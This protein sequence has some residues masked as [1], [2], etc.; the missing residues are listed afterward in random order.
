MDQDR[1]SSWLALRAVNGIGD[2]LYRRLIDKFGSPQN[3]FSAGENELLKVEGIRSDTVA[4]IRSAAPAVPAG[5]KAGIPE[6]E[7]ILFC[8]IL[9]RDY[10]DRVR[11][12]HDPP[13]FLF[14]KGGLL[15]EDR[16]SIAVVGSRNC[17][18]YGRSVAHAL[19]RELAL[20]GFTI[21]S[22]LARG[23]DAAAH[24]G[25]LSAG[26][27][28]IGV[29]GCGLDIAYPPG[30]A[31]LKSE[32]AANGAVITEFPFGTT[33]DPVNFPKR[34][35]LISGLS[36]G[37]IVVEAAEKSGALITASYA[38]D[39]GREVF[40]VPGPMGSETSRGPHL[41]I[42]QGARL[43]DGVDDILEELRPSLT[44]RVT[45]DSKGV[46]AARL[47]D[48][49]VLTPGERRVFELLSR[50]P[51]HLDEL[52][53]RAKASSSEMAGW[54]LQLELKGAARHLAGQRYVRGEI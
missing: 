19:S 21:V 14:I 9:D 38:L 8:T 41:L 49:L 32:I 31:A 28:T 4:S 3:V 7:S 16:Q 2:V 25:A 46:P 15:P 54:L 26:G 45:E 29:L 48:P 10:P 6:D 11:E 36:L 35:R 39:Q 24:E 30:H 40:A 17:T 44:A 18:E 13:P 43:V 50:N 20:L 5:R 47:P 52:T 53:A 1:M 37:V 42:R 23:I 51:Q 33:P 12:I 27:R 22:G 34:N